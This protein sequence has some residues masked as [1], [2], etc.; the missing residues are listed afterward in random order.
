MRAYVGPCAFMRSGVP[1]PPGN[2]NANI[3]TNSN[4]AS[5]ATSERSGMVNSA[6]ET[7]LEMYGIVKDVR[8][9]D[10]GQQRQAVQADAALPQHRLAGKHDRRV[11]RQAASVI[12]RRHRLLGFDEMVAGEFVFHLR[13]ES[14]AAGV[15]I[16]AQLEHPFEPDLLQVGLIGRRAVG[17]FQF[18]PAADGADQ[19]LELLERAR[20]RGLQA[21]DRNR[22]E[23]N[24]SELQ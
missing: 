21:A 9:L 1:G 8:P 24:T 22:S 17:G 2:M 13:P 18:D 12:R 10:A 6:P 5:N 7:E 23:E 16:V 14:L 3:T 19:L 15:V 11:E 20:H 4:S